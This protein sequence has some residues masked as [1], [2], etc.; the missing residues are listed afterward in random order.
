MCAHF[1]LK[2]TADQISKKIGIKVPQ[3]LNFD[4][5][6]RGYMKTEMAP[7][8]L[9]E[10]GKTVV[11]NAYFS[12][13]PSWSKEFPCQFSTYNARLERINPKTGKEEY[14][15]QVPS[16][17]ESF[18]NGKT[19]LVPMQK[20]IESSYFGTHAG[21]MI[22]FKIKNDDIFF[23]TGIY[24][25]YVNKDNGEIFETFTLLTDSPYPFFF[26]AGHDR[27]IVVIDYENYDEWLKNKKLMPIDRFNFL[28]ENRISL[29]WEVE[30]ERPLKSGWE[31][32]APTNEEIS[33]IK[34]WRK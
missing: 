9:F 20:A 7:I 24:S 6:V 33:T 16:W 2:A 34:I 12:L 5:S 11:K 31:K 25:E 26:N 23:A 8:V 19:C 28:R 3:D 21:N 4:I 15:F 30:V 18:N 13:C 22:G 17:K 27:S 1:T 32:R 14:I 29:D 10:D